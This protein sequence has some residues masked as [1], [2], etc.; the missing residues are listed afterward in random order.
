MALPGTTFSGAENRVSH[1]PYH[2]LYLGL[3]MAQAVALGAWVVYSA[4]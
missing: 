3:L 1:F 2:A 4:L